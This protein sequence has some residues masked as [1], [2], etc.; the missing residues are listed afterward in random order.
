[1]ANEFL[2]L[3]HCNNWFSKNRKSAVIVF[4]LWIILLL[5][6]T[7][8]SGSNVW[9]S[10]TTMAGLVSTDKQEKFYRT[11][12]FLHN[13]WCTYNPYCFRPETLWSFS[14]AAWMSVPAREMIEHK[15]N[16]RSDSSSL[17][18]IF[19]LGTCSRRSFMK[20]LSTFSVSPD[21]RIKQ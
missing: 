6:G 15:S 2:F 21:E 13:T 20:P 14:S 12:I 1:M 16:M 3:L 10:T 18:T 11:C 4:S 8:W 17:S 19:R 5:S 9:W 7:T